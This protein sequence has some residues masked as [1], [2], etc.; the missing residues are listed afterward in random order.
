MGGIRTRK[1]SAATSSDH[2]VDRLVWVQRRGVNVH[3]AVTPSSKGGAFGDA[4]WLSIEWNDERR[5][6][7]AEWKRFATSGEFRASTT[8][9]LEA[10]REKKST[11]LVSDKRRLEGVTD[12][13]QLWIRDTWTPMAIDSGLKRIVVVVL[14]HGLGK[15]ATEEILTQV[16]MKVFAT[17]MFS[18]VSEA[19]EW[20]SE[21]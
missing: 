7:Y 10:I 17:R 9:I 11:A 6:V 3:F 15:I 14:R 18:T 1:L 4:P 5:Y 19:A 2:R 20:V 12:Q 16:E 8:R 13:D 21:T